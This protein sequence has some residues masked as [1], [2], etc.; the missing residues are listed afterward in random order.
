V[1][2]NQKN[3]QAPKRVLAFIRTLLLLSGQCESCTRPKRSPCDLRF[4]SSSI[5]KSHKFS[6]AYIF[7]PLSQSNMSIPRALQLNNDGVSA[8][9]EGNENLAIA[10]LA[11]SIRL[12][13]QELAI[14]YTSGIPATLPGHKKGHGSSASDESFTVSSNQETN[15]TTTIQLP[16]REEQHQSFIFNEAFAIRACISGDDEDHCTEQDI[17]I[18]TSAVIFNLALSYHRKADQESLTKADKL[19]NMVLKLLVNDFTS[20]VS[21]LV[22]LASI[23]NM[24]QIRFQSGNFVSAAAGLDHLTS[25]MRGSAMASADSSS[26]AL[27]SRPLFQ[28]PQIKGLLMNVLL[29]KVPKVAPAA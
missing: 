12:L 24:A 29:L 22:K 25:F 7:S 6:I 28:E 1:S 20:R 5:S 11:Q 18:Y 16:E 8:L 10:S 2:N 27:S 17:H 3:A 13:K 19:Y 14:R 9:M 26:G 15:K 21:V 4:S 23:N